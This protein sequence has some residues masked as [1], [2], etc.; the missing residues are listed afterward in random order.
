[1][2]GVQANENG[3]QIGAVVSRVNGLRGWLVAGHHQKLQA[4]SLLQSVESNVTRFVG[5]EYVVLSD[6]TSSVPRTILGG[7][8]AAAAAGNNIHSQ[9]Q[10]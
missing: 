7:S 4:L 6:G 9:L 3:F 8:D 10:I 5:K 2:L 1:M